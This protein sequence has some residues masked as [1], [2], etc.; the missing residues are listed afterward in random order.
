VRIPP[1][2]PMASRDSKE[3]R[4]EGRIDAATKPSM[5]A[6]LVSWIQTI[7]GA[8][9]EI[10]SRTMGRFFKQPNPCV[11][12]ET[13]LTSRR[14]LII[15]TANTGRITGDT[16]ERTH[17]HTHAQATER[18][19]GDYGTRA[20]ENRSTSRPQEATALAR[21]RAEGPP[22]HR[23]RKA[24]RRSRWQRRTHRRHAYGGAW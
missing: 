23:H 14:C 15:E 7:E 3:V 13:I 5:E 6:S 16:E 20:G 17:K 19:E 4:P 22:N 24:P 10:A 8:A 18:Q 2:L 12:H 11:F 21:Q 1:E 9:E